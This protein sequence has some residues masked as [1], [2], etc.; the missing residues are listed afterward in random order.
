MRSS[1]SAFAESIARSMSG[2]PPGENQGAE[3][4]ETRWR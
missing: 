1:S 4:F 2:S 3:F